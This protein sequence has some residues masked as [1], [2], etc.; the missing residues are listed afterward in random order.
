MVVDADNKTVFQSLLHQGISLLGKGW[1]GR[2]ASRLSWFQ[3]LLHQGISLLS[4]VPARNARSCWAFQSLLHQGISLLLN[5]RLRRPKDKRRFN[6]F[7]IRASVYW[8][9]TGMP[10]G[11]A[12]R[13]VSIP[14][15]SGHQFTGVRRPRGLH[16]GRRAVSIPSSSGHQ[17]TVGKTDR[18][19][20][21][22]VGVSI[23]SSSGHQFTA[24]PRPLRGD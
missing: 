19:R 22:A 21:T 12:C 8:G 9:L 11:R 13:A 17:F 16:H 7:F 23:P 1:H 24:R 14:S 20:E 6:P 5:L 3:S 15:S 4:S 18:I 2:V 10:D